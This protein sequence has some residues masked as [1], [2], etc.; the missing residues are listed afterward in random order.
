MQRTRNTRRGLHIRAVAGVDQR[1]GCV[2]LH[3]GNVGTHRSARWSPQLRLHVRGVREDRAV[4]RV[5][6]TR[7]TRRGLHIGAIPCIDQGRRRVHLH[8]GDVS[9]NR[10]SSRSPDIDIQIFEALLSRAV[11]VRH[12]VRGVRHVVGVVLAEHGHQVVDDEHLIGELDVR[13]ESRGGE[14]PGRRDVVGDVAAGRFRGGP[15]G[16]RVQRH[17]EIVA[18]VEVVVPVAGQLQDG[19]GGERPER[20][21]V[22]GAAELE[23]ADLGKRR[24]DGSLVDEV[25][26]V[27]LEERPVRICRNICGCSRV[28]S[29][30]RT[31]QVARHLDGVDISPVGILKVVGSYEHRSR[32][33][34][35]CFVVGPHRVLAND[36]SR[37][38]REPECPTIRVNVHDIVE[39]HSPVDEHRTGIDR[40]I[41]ETADNRI[42]NNTY[43]ICGTRNRD[44]F[45]R[46]G[47]YG[48]KNVGLDPGAIRRYSNVDCYKRLPSCIRHQDFVVLEREVSCIDVDS[49]R[50]RINPS[51]IEY[52]VADRHVPSIDVDVG[53]RSRPEGEGGTIP[54]VAKTTHR[55]TCSRHTRSAEVDP[56]RSRD[57][58]GV[59]RHDQD[60]VTPSCLDMLESRLQPREGLIA[61][62]GSRP[63]IRRRSARIDEEDPS[64]RE[65]IPASNDRD[66]V[67]RDPVRKVGERRLRHQKWHNQREDQ[68]Q[69]L[70]HS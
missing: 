35:T 47:Y 14:G 4:L 40:S 3:R 32:I 44:R 68:D 22:H 20:S 18:R 11:R 53:G 7:N 39:R 8:R 5:Q 67:R 59:R 13:A 62:P 12:D 16:T 23:P 31:D 69:L 10:S 15:G 51:Q 43:V 66:P 41:F 45:C 57:R 50:Y 65:H 19:M 37:C 56:A 24:D 49:S 6:R 61:G 25:L 2:H 9:T 52:A 46:S 26:L 21:R 30:V 42:V 27:S 54:A 29:V 1:R 48:M 70:S 28:V 33:Q 17:A 36:P 34:R 38:R 60:E 63:R 58:L 55:H 64:G